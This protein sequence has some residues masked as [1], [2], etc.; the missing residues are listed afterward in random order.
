MTRAGSRPPLLDAPYAPR[1]QAAL[2]AAFQLHTEV[3]CA[4]LEEAADRALGVM[5]AELESGRV[6]EG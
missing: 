5:I 1:L 3:L 6:D 4:L 2:Q